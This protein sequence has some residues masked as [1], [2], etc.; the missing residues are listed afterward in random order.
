MRPSSRRQ[1]SK[2]GAYFTIL[3]CIVLLAALTF[4]ITKSSRNSGGTV[5]KERVNLYA[6]QVLEQ[7]SDIQAGVNKLEQRG[8][9]YAQMQFAWPPNSS[10]PADHSC[11]LFDSA[12]ANL[13]QPTVPIQIFV[14]S[15]GWGT[16]YMTQ[17]ELNLDADSAGCPELYF[18]LIDVTAAFC[19]A[20][21]QAAG[22]GLSTIP[23]LVDNGGGLSYPMN[24]C[25]VTNYPALSSPL[26]GVT[27]FCSYASNFPAYVVHYLL[28][29]N[30]TR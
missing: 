1:N 22:N 30:V 23:S 7:L 20:F 3:L 12:G 25:N 8:C 24:A 29:K 19:A 5:G 11:D 4:A 10:A 16:A 6:Q 27:A 28:A 18:S 13:V 15:P 17:D 2:G 9:T 21:N 26:T 14:P